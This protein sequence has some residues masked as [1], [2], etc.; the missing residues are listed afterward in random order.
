ME[1]AASSDS[2]EKSAAGAG[3][4]KEENANLSDVA[5]LERSLREEDSKNGVA[6]PEENGLA[7]P[8]ENAAVEPE[9]NGPAESDENAA[10]ESEENG[11][12]PEEN[13]AG[14]PEETPGEEDAV[15]SGEKKV[16]PIRIE[17]YAMMAEEILQ[18]KKTEAVLTGQLRGRIAIGY[19]VL[20]IFPAKGMQQAR[21]TRIETAPGVTAAETGDGRCSITIENP[22]GLRDID[23]YSVM[24]DILPESRP[25]SGRPIENPY[26]LGLTGS[27]KSFVKDS[28]FMGS[29]IFALVHANFLLPISVD[30]SAVE[31]S[32]QSGDHGIPG[33]RVRLHFVADPKKPDTKTLP[34]FTDAA[35]M[36]KWKQ[37]FEGAEKP[38]IMLMRFPDAVRVARREFNGLLLNAFGTDAIFLSNDFLTRITEM[39]AFKKEFH[40]ADKPAAKKPAAANEEQA[41]AAAEGSDVVSNVLREQGNGSGQT[42]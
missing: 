36:H 31:E 40:I 5:W 6:E 24:T 18:F 26:L 38:R 4:T 33:T 12:E 13:G 35:A 42:V 23:K 9:E 34:I 10:G 3:E 17:R 39:D 14:K 22:G 8:G 37:V 29:F 28:R 25:K 1:D 19:P 30:E 32:R 41:A 16:S 2:A 27:F 15:S 11:P 20:I 21:V 7:E